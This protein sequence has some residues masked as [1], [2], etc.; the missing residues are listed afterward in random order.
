MEDAELSVV[1][2]FPTPTLSMVIEAVE[3]AVSALP[4]PDCDEVVDASSVGTIEG[5]VVEAR[6]ETMTG[7][8]RVGGVGWLCST[9]TVRVDVA[10][11][12]FWAVAT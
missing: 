8:A 5:V 4:C 11:R 7:V 3:V 9:M 2:V 6:V 1:G 10:V 12:P